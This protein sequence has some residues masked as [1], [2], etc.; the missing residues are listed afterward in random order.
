M[1]KKID[2]TQLH[3]E[4]LFLHLTEKIEDEDYRD[5]VSLIAIAIPDRNEMLAFLEKT[6]KDGRRL[7]A[8]YPGL[9]Q[10]PSSGMDLVGAIPDG[11]LYVK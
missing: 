5:T 8:I 7:Y 3:G 4:D 11:A 1:S 10:R 9:K 6:I 2:L